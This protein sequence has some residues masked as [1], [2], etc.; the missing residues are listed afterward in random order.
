MKNNDDIEKNDLKQ[1]APKLCSINNEN[2]FGVPEN[3]FDK[4]ADEISDRCNQP[5][6]K[7]AIHRETIQKVIIPLAIAAS[8]ILIILFNYK[9]QEINT[10]PNAQAVYADN[11]GTSEYLENLIDDNELDESLI[12]SAIVNDDTIASNAKDNHD[13]EKIKA[14]NEN[15][16]IITDSVSNTT[17]TEDDIIQYLLEDDEADDL[18]N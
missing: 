1:T 8:V 2:P 5:E 7:K 9:K 3:Y 11:S 13:E 12:V 6:K 16:V 14:M 15:P 18:L 4:L 10:D 17:I